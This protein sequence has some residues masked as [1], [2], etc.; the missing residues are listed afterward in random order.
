[1]ATLDR[2]DLEALRPDG[3]IR[4]RPAALLSPVPVVLVGCRGT[5][6][7]TARPNLI[8]I[9]WTGTVC[10]DP[11]LVS[12]SIRKSRFSH[13]QVTESGEFTVNLVDASLLRAADLCGVKS[14]RD[15]DKFAL[16]GLQAADSDRLRHAP[17]LAESP[18]T[19][20]CRVRS[21]AELGSHDQ[22][23]GEVVGV[24]VRPDLLGEDGRLSLDR[25]N[26][27]GYLHGEYWSLG[28]C[29]GFFGFSVAAPAVLSRR[30][31]GRG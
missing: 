18:L 17:T 9:A 20:E 7:A 21:V 16:C 14:G 30:M 11:P 27:V 8:A 26:L 31:K 10:S 28:R 22:F 23:L 1:M 2:N 24:T 13:L 4:L 3:R 6:E 29:L 5:T 12:V 19:L 25:A 15:V